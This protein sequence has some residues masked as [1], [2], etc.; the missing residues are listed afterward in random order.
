[1][2]KVNILIVEDTKSDADNLKN[3]LQNMGYNICGLAE[4]GK[5]ALAQF[6]SSEPD[7]IILDI[8]LK[9]EMSG[10]DVANRIVKDELCKKPILFVTADN[11]SDTFENAKMTQPIAYLL[12]PYN[13]FTLQHQI[14]LAIH[15]SNPV[16]V[17]LQLHLREGC[18]R[19]ISFI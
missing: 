10:I 16:E 11:T 4:T 12:K 13:K 6:Y 2:S 19:I 7:L 3:D 5:E 17:S 1:M 9:G 8:Q 15:Y 14:E 18:L